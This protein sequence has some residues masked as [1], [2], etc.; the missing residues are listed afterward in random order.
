MQHDNSEMNTST[1]TRQGFGFLLKLF[2]LLC[3]VPSQ[4]SNRGKPLVKSVLLVAFFLTGISA[5]FYIDAGPEAINRG[6]LF[7]AFNRVNSLGRV[8]LLA[9]AVLSPTISHKIWKDFFST[10]VS[11][12]SKLESEETFSL[13]TRRVVLIQI[14][15]IHLGYI[16]RFLVNFFTL[17]FDTDIKSTCYSLFSNLLDYFILMRLMLSM[18][19][20][21]IVRRRFTIINE[22]LKNGNASEEMTT[23]CLIQQP[24]K[25]YSIQDVD[26]DYRLANNLIKQLNT[27]FGYQSLVLMGSV[28]LVLLETLLLTTYG[29]KGNIS[30]ICSSAIQVIYTLVSIYT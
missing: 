3:L 22:R 30:F 4:E 28:V 6:V 27:L 16:M 26:V 29:V 23:I 2:E 9:L 20:W 24:V 7:R 5:L 25:R 1:S 21:L 18:N 12:N 13:I 10:L 14:I 11:V 8:L 15:V 19:L 17:N